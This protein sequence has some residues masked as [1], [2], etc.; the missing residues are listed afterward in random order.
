MEI[1]QLIQL[2][3]CFHGENDTADSTVSTPLLNQVL[4]QLQHFF[5]GNNYYAAESSA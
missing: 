1:M 4:N 2:P 5:H 3:S